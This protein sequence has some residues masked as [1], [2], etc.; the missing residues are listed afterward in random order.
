[1]TAM[2]RTVVMLLRERWPNVSLSGAGSGRRHGPPD[3]DLGECRMAIGARAR[4][5]GEHG[6]RSSN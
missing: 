2:V 1:M 3:G 6:K 5:W 4:M